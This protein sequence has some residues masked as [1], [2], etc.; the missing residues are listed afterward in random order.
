MKFI[1][2]FNFIAATPGSM[3]VQLERTYHSVT[4]PDQE[5]PP[6]ER[7]KGY[8]YGKNWVRVLFFIVELI[9]FFF[10]LF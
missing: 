2:F 8:R 9:C 1:F 3:A 6:N 10:S 4:N 5:I 7:I